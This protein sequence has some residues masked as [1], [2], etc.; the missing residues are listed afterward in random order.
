MKEVSLD[1]MYMEVTM[2]ERKSVLEVIENQYDDLFAREKQV[3]DYVKA[4]PEKVIM[5]NV[6]ELAEECGVSVATIVRMSQHIGYQGYHQMRLFLSRDV[7]R[8][9]ER[10]E[11][12][13]SDTVSMVL[14]T[15]MNALKGLLVNLD[16]QSLQDAAKAIVKAE[17]VFIVAVGNTTPVAHDLEFRLGRFGIRAYTSDIVMTYLNYISLGNEKDVVIAISKSGESRKVVQ[18]AEMAKEIG[19]K[20]ISVTGE[21]HSP[22]AQLADHLLCVGNKNKLFNGMKEPESHVCEMALNDILLYEIKH[23]H[24]HQRG[25]HV[26]ELYSDAVTDITSADKM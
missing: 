5:M 9:E 12:D 25:L 24:S 11:L 2:Q 26:W 1:E 15:C 20:V 18:A 22:L 10:R 6:S 13:E 7:G 14:D 23:I 16:K 4:Y 8:E 21:K 19:M 17:N 3:A